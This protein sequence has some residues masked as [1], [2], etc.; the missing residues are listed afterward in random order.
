M[1]AALLS[2]ARWAW[3][4]IGKKAVELVARPEDSDYAGNRTHQDGT[5]LK[6]GVFGAAACEEVDR[7]PRTLGRGILAANDSIA[8]KSKSARSFTS[9]R[10]S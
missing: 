7:L 3:R 4:P 2:A 10:D 9:G 1:V 8:K 6:G 5:A